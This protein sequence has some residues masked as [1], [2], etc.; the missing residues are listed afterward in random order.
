MAVWLDKR[1]VFRQEYLGIAIA[2]RQAVGGQVYIATGENDECPGKRR[3]KDRLLELFAYIMAM[4]CLVR[5]NPGFHFSD[6][7]KLV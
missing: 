4:G 1:A 6:A 2:S 3:E 5:V 7:Q